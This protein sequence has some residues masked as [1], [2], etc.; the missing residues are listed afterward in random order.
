MTPAEEDI[1]LHLVTDDVEGC[2]GADHEMVD[3]SV[4]ETD[5]G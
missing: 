1:T 2:S 5:T 3:V 4:E